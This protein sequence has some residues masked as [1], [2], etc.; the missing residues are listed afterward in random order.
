MH[1]FFDLSLASS[2]SVENSL[3]NFCAVEQLTQHFG[4]RRCGSRTLGTK[5]LQLT[6]LPPVLCVHLKRFRLADDNRSVNKLGKHI[7]FPETL[8]MRPYVAQ[9]HLSQAVSFHLYGVIS[10]VGPSANT[11]TY[12]CYV[13]DWYGNWHECRDGESKLRLVGIEAVLRSSAYVL[14]YSLNPSEIAQHISSNSSNSNSNSSASSSSSDVPASSSSLA[15]PPSL[16]PSLPSPVGSAPPAKLSEK[17]PR[18]KKPKAP[19]QVARDAVRLKAALTAPVV[20]AWEGKS[21]AGERQH[22]ISE[23]QPV[24]YQKDEW[25]AA[26]DAGH[27]KKVRQKKNKRPGETNPFQSQQAVLAKKKTKSEEQRLA[28]AIHTDL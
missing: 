22:I 24:V 10:H 9:D 15:S 11:G 19:P 6:H 3:R 25:D 28:H 17:Q 2:A 23:L 16:A 13:K 18:A 21:H 20:E 7:S 27:V 1:S 26:L 14:F 5:Q 12:I 4:C 8:D